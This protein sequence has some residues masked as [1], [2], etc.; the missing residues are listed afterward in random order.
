MVSIGGQVYLAETE[1]R[2]PPK[3]VTKIK[4]FDCGVKGNK[5]F[6]KTN[7]SDFISTNSTSGDNKKGIKETINN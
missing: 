1:S 3:M 6:W 2:C 5:F 4:W 7:K